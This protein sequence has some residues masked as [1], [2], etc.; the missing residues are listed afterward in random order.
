V[1]KTSF[2]I[3]PAVLI[4]ITITP[5]IASVV[6]DTTIQLSAIGTFSDGS[7]QDLTTSVSWASASFFIATVD[8]K[9]LVTGVKPGNA[10]VFARREGK[11]KGIFV[12]V[13]PGVVTSI[14]IDPVNPTTTVG[15]KE[16]IFTA[17]GTFSDG[18]T[19]NV[20]QLTSWISS[21]PTVAT[22][23]SSVPPSTGELLPLMP[24]TATIT[25]T[26][27]GVKNSTLV[28]VGR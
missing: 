10:I 16:I 22:V 9:G 15:S 7:T 20:T 1:G 13:T 8:A 19:Q 4:S 14:T 2:T 11:T 25:A 17:I 26:F 6:K 21:D 18:S 12:R 5:P 23:L 28:T 24:G 27:G 3:T